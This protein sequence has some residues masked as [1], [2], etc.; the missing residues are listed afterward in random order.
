[1]A[2]S[3]AA[4]TGIETPALE[5]AFNDS[6]GEPTVAPDTSR[7]VNATASAEIQIVQ[8]AEQ[9]L[10]QHDNHWRQLSDRLSKRPLT[11]PSLDMDG[12][13]DRSITH[14][15]T[16]Y[17]REWDARRDAIEVEAIRATVETRANGATLTKSFNAMAENETA[18]D[19]DPAHEPSASAPS[20]DATNRFQRDFSVTVAARANDIDR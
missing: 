11:A 20:L 2:E 1:M 14:E 5:Q 13:I 18:S 7:D 15:Y 6:V 8:E 4:D 17:R 10:A 9:A 12:G 16:E 19:R 3:N